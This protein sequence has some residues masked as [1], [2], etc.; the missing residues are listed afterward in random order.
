MDS[1]D[2]WSQFENT[3]ESSKNHFKNQPKDLILSVFEFF[4]LCF[5]HKALKEK[6]SLFAKLKLVSV[7]LIFALQV[8]SLIYFSDMK[9]QN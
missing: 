2:D 1:N 5:S 7:H 4:Y 9:I 8:I 6:I 3:R